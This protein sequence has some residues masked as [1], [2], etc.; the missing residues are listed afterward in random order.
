MSRLQYL[1]FDMDGTLYS[2]ETGL[3]SQ[4]GYRIEHWLAENLELTLKAAKWLRREYYILYGTTMGGLLHDYPHLD[5]DDYLDYVHDIDVTPYLEPDPQLDQ[6]LSNLPLP[7]AIFTNSI[8]D[9]A[10]RIALQLG[11]RQH[12]QHIF[13][14]RTVDYHCKPHPHAF[15]KVLH[16]LGVPGEACVLLDDQPSYLSGAV[17]AGMR[18]I[19]VNPTIAATDGIDAAVP[20]ILDAEPVLQAWLE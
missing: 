9:W 2:D 13:D 17:N 10:H 6:M 15:E 1:L 4:V 11:V 8:S 5:I 20:H 7:K 14:V 19:L 18:T 16:H 12:F 3:F